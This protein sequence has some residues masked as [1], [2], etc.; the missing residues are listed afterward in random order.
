MQSKLEAF[1][2]VASYPVPIFQGESDEKIG[3]RYEA[4]LKGDHTHT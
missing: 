2:K 4:N 1:L 3:S